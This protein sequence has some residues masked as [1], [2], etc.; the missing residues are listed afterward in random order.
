MKGAATPAGTNS[1]SVRTPS[2]LAPPASKTRTDSAIAE[3]HLPS[4]E[5]VSASASR[6]RAG[7][8]KT[9][10]KAAG[11][12]PN[13]ERWAANLA[14]AYD[15]HV[16]ASIG[17][18]SFEEPNGGVAA[19]LTGA[20]AAAVVA[21]AARAAREV[22]AEAGGAAAQAA[23]LQRRLIALAR[24]DAE[25]YAAALDARGQGDEAL[26]EALERAARAPLEIAEAAVDV[27]ALA[28]LVAEHGEVALRAD[29]VTAATL[30][31]AAVRAAATLVEVN[32]GV[33]PHDERLE[34]AR[35]LVAAASRSVT[36]ADG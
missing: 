32:L 25:A 22:W 3:I 21:S 36:Q 16:D 5:P 8:R 6:R 23:K 24:D 13:Q 31:E 30:A 7:F 29:A 28:T 2:A 19:A 20:L 9:P 1:T 17:I 18:D 26:G 12:S 33:L 11:K 15:A 27:V 35:S 34:R 14:R 4:S 10:P